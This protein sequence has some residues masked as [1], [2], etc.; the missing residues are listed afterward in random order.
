LKKSRITAD[1]GISRVLDANLNR[2]IE[3]VR[4]CEEIM[5]FIIRSPGITL[6]FKRIRHRIAACLKGAWRRRARLFVEAR[7]SASDAGRATIVSELK[8]GGYD[9]IFFANIQR[10]KESIRVLEEF[11][12]LE[13]KKLS[14]S[15]KNIRY[16]LYQLEKKATLKLSAIRD[17]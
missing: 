6:E 10:V 5:R 16:D 17:H 3:G 1:K 11:S 9:D 8:R 4:V 13:S 12:K 15:F 2:A 14:G 7:E